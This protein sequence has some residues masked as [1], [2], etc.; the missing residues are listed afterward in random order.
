MTS[1]ALLEMGFTEE[2]RDFLRWYAGYQFADGKIP[3][4]VDRRG[5]D[6]VPEH[7]SNGEFIYAVARVLPLHARR[8]LRR[9]S[10]GRTCVRAVDY[11]AA[12][13]AQAPRPTTYRQPGKRAFYG[14]LPESISHEGYSAHPVHSYWDDFFALRGLKDAAVLAV[15]VGDDDAGRALRGAARRLR[16]A[17]CYASIAA[18]WPIASIDYI[19]GSVELGDFDPTLDRDRH[20]ARRRAGQPAARRRSTRTFERYCDG[21]R[22]APQRR[23]DW[24]AL[25]ALRAAQRRRARAP[26]PARARARAARRICSPTGGRRP[27]TSGPRSSG[28]IA[29]APR[30]IGDMPHTWV[31]SGFVQ[32]GARPC[33]PTSA[34]PIGALVLAAGVPASWVTSDAGRR[35]ARLP[36]HYGIL[37]YTLRRDGADA[38]RVRLSGDLSV[39]PGGIVVQPP[40]PGRLRSVTRQRPAG[41][42]YRRPTASAS[43]SSPPT[44][45]WSTEA[46]MDP[47]GCRA[48]IGSPTRRRTRGCSR[49]GAS[50]CS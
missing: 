28:A 20:R 39:P 45:C 15:V 50:P 36:T 18:A 37:N 16:S 24:D 3:C 13:R 30:F 38:L 35:R 23:G 19:P 46:R 27:G 29:T 10:C 9:T 7:D 22:A 34:R 32:R 2:V 21:R 47:S 5:A 26:R 17:T 14:L 12:L 6:P 42:P 25:H 31:G 49:T 40:L 4:C 11:L 43:T 44:S 8:R 41:R 1:A 33:S 48:S